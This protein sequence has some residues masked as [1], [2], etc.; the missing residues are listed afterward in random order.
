M[1][2]G[3]VFIGVDIGGTKIAVNGI[4]EQRK[5]IAPQWL[6]MPSHSDKGPNATVGQIVAAVQA[7]MQREGITADRIAAVGLDS[8]GPADINGRIEKSANMH[9]DWE[10][11]ELRDNAERELSRALGH[12]VRVSYE[13][14]CNA[15]ALWESHIGN[16]EGTEVM[17]LLAPGTGLGGGIVVHGRL[18]RGSRGMGAELGHLEIVHPPFIEGWEPK[19][20]CG[21]TYCAEAYASMAALGKILRIALPQEKYRNHPL[22]QITGATEEETWKKRAYAVRGLAAQGDELCQA[23]FDWQS[24]AIARLCRQVAD[25]IDPDRIVIGGGFIE[26]GKALTDR[27][28]GIIQ[29]EFRRLA[30]KKHA[31]ELKFEVARSGDQAGCLGAALSAWQFANR[32]G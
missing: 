30:F 24:R 21:Q 19:C 29:E 18:L 22:N 6:E 26:G 16:P 25:T 27:I 12:E 31:A 10:G 3:K 28:M 2:S 15:A 5:A 17:A 1:A 4:D 32:V 20:G 11:F 8:P 14:D 9:P 23:I 13:N 7:F